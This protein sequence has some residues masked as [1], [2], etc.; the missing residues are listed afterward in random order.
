MEK[1]QTLLYIFPVLLTFYLSFFQ[2]QR[3]WMKKSFLLYCVLS[4]VFGIIWLCLPVIPTNNKKLF[5]APLTW[6]FSCYIAQVVHNAF[7]AS[8][9]KSKPIVFATYSAMTGK[10]IYNESLNR[11]PNFFDFCLSAFAVVG[12]T[13]LMLLASPLINYLFERISI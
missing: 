10:D 4:V 7:A 1:I 2:T 5:I 6:V 3:L 13:I 11:K 12:P 8:E 9:N